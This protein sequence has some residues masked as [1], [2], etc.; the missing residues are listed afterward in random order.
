MG[1]LRP[2]EKCRVCVGWSSLDAWG[3]MVCQQQPPYF[4]L[5]GDEG[6]SHGSLVRVG[7]CLP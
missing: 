6:G 2:L 5:V 3:G 1:K 7:R 4:L